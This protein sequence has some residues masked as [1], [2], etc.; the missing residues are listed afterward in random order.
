MDPKSAVG[1]P[2]LISR[3]E[4]GGVYPC[5]NF[6]A[7]FQE[8]Q[9]WSIKGVFVSLSS[10]EFSLMFWGSGGGRVGSSR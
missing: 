8:V 4:G 1:G 10:L 7:L 3:T 5:P 2:K 9:F 6:L